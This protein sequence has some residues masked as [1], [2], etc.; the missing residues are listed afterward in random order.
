MH[1]RLFGT[2]T[3]AKLNALPYYSDNFAVSWKS[4]QAKLRKN[5]FAI[6][7]NF[8]GSA[9]GRLYLNLG[10]KFPYQLLFQTGSTVQIVSASTVFNRDL[11]IL[12]LIFQI[13]HNTSENYSLKRSYK[14]HLLRYTEED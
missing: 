14:I 9:E 6:N 10:S 7:G 13:I 5:K 1:C 3:T 4:F 2:N 12:L 8:I 11:H